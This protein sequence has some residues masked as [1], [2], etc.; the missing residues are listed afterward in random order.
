MHGENSLDSTG[1]NSTHYVIY[2]DDTNSDVLHRLIKIEPFGWLLYAVGGELFLYD[3]VAN[4]NDTQTPFIKITPPPP[5]DDAF[6]DFKTFCLNST[7]TNIESL[8]V[9]TVPHIIPFDILKLADD[10]G[11]FTIFDALNHLQGFALQ[12]FEEKTI[13]ERTSEKSVN[14]RLLNKIYKHAI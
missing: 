9:G 5:V 3:T 10:E 14:L 6:Y 11:R 13:E 2:D 4:C 7:L 12:I 1:I 8:F